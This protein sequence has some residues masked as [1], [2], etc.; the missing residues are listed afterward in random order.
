MNRSIFAPPDVL[1]AHAPITIMMMSR[2][3]LTGP[4]SLKSGS[5]MPVEESMDTAWNRGS[6][7]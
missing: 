6:M 1:P 5:V 2:I 4:Q 3:A 7:V